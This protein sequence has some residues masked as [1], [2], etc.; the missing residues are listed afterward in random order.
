MRQIGGGHNLGTC[1]HFMLSLGVNSKQKDTLRAI[2]ENPARA[3]IRWTRVELL[4]E[5]LGAEFEG[6]GGSRVGVFLRGHRIVLHRP[7]P[8]PCMKKWAVRTVREFLAS[9]EIKP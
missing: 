5:A 7:H 1:Y 6:Q 2:Y 3:D 9:L 8:S 4:L